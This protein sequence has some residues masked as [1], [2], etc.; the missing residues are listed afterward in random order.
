M[1][2]HFS[3]LNPHSSILFT[4]LVNIFYT[5]VSENINAILIINL[6]LSQTA[7]AVLEWTPIS[8]ILLRYKYNILHEIQL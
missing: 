6:A 5:F 1:L 3:D 2:M 8:F 4:Q 7:V